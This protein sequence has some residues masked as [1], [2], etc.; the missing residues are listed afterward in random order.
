MSQPVLIVILGPTAI[1]KT[2]LAIDVASHFQTEII[3][4]DSRQIFRELNIGVARPSEEDLARVRHHFIASASIH[5]HVS[6]GRYAEQARRLLD[7]LFQRHNV[8]V[9][10]GG[11]MLYLDAFIHGLDDL[12]GNAEVRKQLMQE[13]DEKG[14]S[15]LTERLKALDPDYYHQVDLS[16]PHRVIR[17]LE[18]CTV[19]GRPFSALRTSAQQ[20]LP[21]WVVKVGIQAP[22]EEVYRRIDERVVQMIHLGLVEEARALLPHRALNALNTVGYQ[23]VFEYMDGVRDMQMTIQK[24]QQHTRNFAKRQLTWWRRDA[25][26]HW[27]SGEQIRS[28]DFQF[29]KDRIQG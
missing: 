11:S 25:D 5:E 24:I 2:A 20:P 16:N 4:A 17:A 7:A 9:C 21:C 28:S 10:A 6:A 18:V 12:P 29:I 13:L 26:I 15:W 3:S 22:R 1:G 23:E 27:A 19:A 8:V 14:L